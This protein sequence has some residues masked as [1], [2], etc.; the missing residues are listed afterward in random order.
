ML[1][2]HPLIGLWLYLIIS[3]A[4]S[5]GNESVIYQDFSVHRPHICLTDEGRYL[6]CCLEKLKEVGLGLHVDG[7]RIACMHLFS[8]ID[9]YQG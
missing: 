6:Y 7:T 5:G 3:E 1:L 4:G 2:V 9:L 8:T